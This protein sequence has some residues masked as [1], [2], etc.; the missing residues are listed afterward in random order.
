MTGTEPLPELVSSTR[1]GSPTRL[2]RRLEGDLDNILLM[3]LR[4]EPARRY[5][6]V[7]QLAEDIRRHLE[8][9]PVNATKGSWSYRARKFVRR[10]RTGVTAA[11]LV[12]FAVVAGVA[13]TIRQADIA[14]REA[15]IARIER[16][17]AERRFED[18]RELANSLIF[19]IHDSI[20]TLPGAT[21]SRKLLLDRAVQY[22]DKLSQD[23]GGDLTLQRE[24][25]WAYQRLANV[26]GDTSQA[27]LGQVNAADVSNRKA[28][29]LFETVAKAD[30]NNLTDQI[31]LAMAYRW[32][33]FFDIYEKSG[34]AEIDR[35]LAI[36]DPLTATHGDNL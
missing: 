29:A 31:N 1:E 16:A 14:R 30:P 28:T 32:R 34:R 18:V 12:F 22:L 4:K 20:Q 3:A 25:A 13:A 21:P 9:L 19:E 8:G 15:E 2:R 26:Q 10:N 7:E 5:L 17:R 33:A 24:L 11:A 36:T 23:S 27:N 35:A 6:S